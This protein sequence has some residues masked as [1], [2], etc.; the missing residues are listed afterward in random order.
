MSEGIMVAAAA[1]LIAVVGLMAAHRGWLDEAEREPVD[2][3]TI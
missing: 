3:Y 2:T 1:A